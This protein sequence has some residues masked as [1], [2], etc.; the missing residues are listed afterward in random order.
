MFKVIH[1][2][3]IAI[4]YCS[5]FSLNSLTIKLN[6]VHFNYNESGGFSFGIK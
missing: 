5:F 3:C 4:E 2:R 1:L 6:H